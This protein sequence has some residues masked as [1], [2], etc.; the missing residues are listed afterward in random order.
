MRTLHMITEANVRDAALSVPK[1]LQVPASRYRASIW[2]LKNIWVRACSIVTAHLPLKRF[3][4]QAPARQVLSIALL[5]DLRNPIGAIYAAAELL[6]DLDA[7]STQAKRLATNIYRAAGRARELLADVSS[8]CRQVERAQICDLREVIAVASEAASATIQNQN[9]Q[10][11]IEAA[12]GIDLPLIRSRMERVFFN[13]VINALEAMPTGGALN[14]RCR[15]ASSHVLIEVEDT[16]PGIPHH[17]RDRLFGPFVTAGK[18]NGLGLGLAT[19]RQTVYDHGGDMWS[20]PARGA[21]FV[22]R[23]PMQSR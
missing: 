10:I 6:K 2:G 12:R 14:I 1:S 16:G 15:E 9:V 18:A 17:I 8:P 13:L 5:H 20:E 23:L 21:R 19:S 3:H 11:R 22:I 4:G 7:G